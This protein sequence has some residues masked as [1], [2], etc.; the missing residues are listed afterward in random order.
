MRLPRGIVS[1][2]RG[3]DLKISFVV[4]Y[5]YKIRLI[6]IIHKSASVICNLLNS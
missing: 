3:K 6:S 2:W 1:L 4:K 5:V